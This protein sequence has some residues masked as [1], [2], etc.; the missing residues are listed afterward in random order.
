MRY[1]SLQAKLN[2][3]TIARDFELLSI[4]QWLYIG[5]DSTWRVQAE[6]QL[7][8]AIPRLSIAERL[9]KATWQLR[10]PYI[11]W[12]GELSLANDSVEWW[13]SELAAKN[14]Y[15]MMFVRVCLL[16]VARQMISA[17]LPEA[18]FV[19]CS[20]PALLTE[21]SQFARAQGYSLQVQAP[22]PVQLPSRL[23][24]F[25]QFLAKVP[26]HARDFG[27]SK[28][29]QLGLRASASTAMELPPVPSDIPLRYQ[30]PNE[31]KVDYWYR[32]LTACGFTIPQDFAGERTALLFTWVDKRNFNPDGSYRDPHLGPLAALLR[33]RGYR[34]AYVPRLLGSLPFAEAVERLARCGETFI[35]PELVL[36]SGDRQHCAEQAALFQPQIPSDSNVAGIPISRLAREHV[37]QTR[38]AHQYALTYAPLVARLAAVGVQPERIVHTWEGHSWEQVLAWTARANWSDTKVIGFDNG[39]FPRLALSLFPAPGE[40]AIRPLP[41]WIV[42]GGE[43][44]YRVLLEQ[45]WPKERLRRGCALRHVSMWQ[46]ENPPPP[47]TTLCGQPPYRILVATTIGLGDSVELLVKAIQAFG[48]DP[49]FQIVVKCHPVTSSQQLMP[50]LDGY[51]ASNITFVT[52]PIPELLRT[53]RIALYAYTLVCLEALHQGVVPVF[54]TSETFLNLDKL[55]ATP[56]VRGLAR[57]PAELRQTVCEI[58]SWSDRQRLQ[59]QTRSAEVVL[60]SLSPLTSE[61][62]QAFCA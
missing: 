48:D 1:I 58:L 24:Q 35:F 57:T 8:P 37:E 32:W 17:G 59:W 56:D 62:V 45:G 46:E 54:V 55:D 50:Y 10:Q 42:T 14:V 5:E 28:L 30:Q 19:V 61:C 26:V 15:Y 33:D 3:A 11:D 27:R 40:Y 36:T 13:A 12:I 23:T 41:D 34:V 21:V 39:N 4:Q 9:D 38:N 6:Y 52:T 51:A 53:V 43:T 60:A 20:T 7:E 44:L 2:L 29:R 16:A 22:V 25:G 49:K 47:A 31:T 18:T